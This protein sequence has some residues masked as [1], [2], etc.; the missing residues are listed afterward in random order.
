MATQNNLQYIFENITEGSVLAFYHKEWYYQTIPFF[1]RQKK[2]E[3]VPHHVAICYEVK[4]QGETLT[5]MLSEQTFQG[6]KYR[7]IVIHKNKNN[8]YYIFDKYFKSQ[9]L[10]TLHKINMSSEQVKFGIEDAKKQVGKRYGFHKLIFGA[11]FLEKVLP[12]KFFKWL[13][14]KQ[15]LRVCSTHIAYNLKYAGFKV[16]SDD[17]MTPLEII[18]L[19]IYA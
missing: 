12:K 15:G 11:E 18:N 6:G 19:D 5:F 14:K 1:T 10:I 16:P 8:N 2:K 3:L 13:N 4:K 7:P 17:F 9:E